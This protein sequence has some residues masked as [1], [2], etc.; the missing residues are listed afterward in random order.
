MKAKTLADSEQ[1]FVEFELNKV[2]TEPCATVMMTSAEESMTSEIKIEPVQINQCAAPNSQPPWVPFQQNK[3]ERCHRSRNYCCVVGCYSKEEDPIKFF[4]FPRKTLPVRTELWRKAIKRVNADG[5]E[6]YPHSRASIC[7][8]HFVSGRPSRTRADPDYVPSIFPTTSKGHMKVK[9]LAESE[10]TFVEFEVNKVKTEP[11][12]T[13]MMTSAEESMTSEIKIEPV[14]INQ[15]AAPNPQPLQVPFQQNKV[16]WIKSVIDPPQVD[17]YCCV[18]GC[19]SKEEDPINFFRF[20]RTTLPVRTE[21]WRKAINRVNADGSEWY[22]HSR[23]SICAKHFISGRPSGTKSDPDYVPSL[24]P[25]TEGHMKAKTLA[26]SER[27]FVEF[28]EK[29]EPCA[30]VMMTS[31]VESMTSEIKIKHVQINQCA[32]TNPQPP[33]VLFQQDKVL[34][35]KS[36]IDPLQ[37]DIKDNC[38]DPL[39]IERSRRCRH[40]CCVVGCH[41]NEQDLVKFFTFRWKTFPVRTEL[42]RKAINRVNADGSE[43]YP[44][45]RAS[46]CSKHFITGRPSGT[47]A[48]PDYVPSIFPTTEG[49]M[50]AKTLADLEGT[51]VEFEVNKVKTE[52]C[53]T[54][55]MTSAEESMTSEIKIEPV[56]INQ[57]AAPNPQP[58]RVLFQQDK[59]ILRKSVIDPRKGNIIVKVTKKSDYS[60]PCGRTKET[61]T[62]DF[63]TTTSTVDFETT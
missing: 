2:K 57:C 56:Q 43:W 3:I 36:V 58:P 47:K 7:A 30:T 25:T 45:T 11:C 59:V 37:V 23:A 35:R 19:Y 60:K 10:R 1:I 12:A 61:S 5:S 17:N 33:R 55:M 48:D 51:F 52:P 32:D 29:T 27:T 21:L 14:Q 26:E 28:E 18:V 42:W 53:A 49:H 4:G 31:A 39:K 15:C 8:K 22:P 40:Y 46:I 50:K 41:S 62:V 13:V 9:T 24:F 38:H 16:L 44:G 6:W 20:L 54:V 63:E 34:W